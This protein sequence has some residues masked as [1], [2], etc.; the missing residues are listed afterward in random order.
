VEQS[1]SERKLKSFFLS[2]SNKELNSVKVED[3]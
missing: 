3:S 1:Q 2:C